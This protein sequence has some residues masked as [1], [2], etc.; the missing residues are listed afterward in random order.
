MVTAAGTLV[1]AKTDGLYTLDQA[2]DDHHLSLLEVR[3]RLE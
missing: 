2:G 1:I 3:A